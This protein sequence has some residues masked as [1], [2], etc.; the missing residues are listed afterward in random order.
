MWEPLLQVFSW[1]LW[2]GIVFSTGAFVAT[3]ASLVHQRR[4]ASSTHLL[5]ESTLLRILVGVAVLGSSM[6]I[7]KALMS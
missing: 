5:E 6:G 7:A 3:I 4:S 1:F 2:F